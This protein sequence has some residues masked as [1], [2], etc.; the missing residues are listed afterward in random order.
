MQSKIYI[1][2][3]SHKQTDLMFRQLGS[4]DTDLSII[5][6]PNLIISL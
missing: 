3:V 5:A 6:N 2:V 4:R 1:S